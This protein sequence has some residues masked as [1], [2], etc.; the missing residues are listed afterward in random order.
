MLGKTPFHEDLLSALNRRNNTL[1]LRFQVKKT[2]IKLTGAV[3]ASGV[4][5]EGGGEH[6]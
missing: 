1:L 6:L 5:V 4:E 3:K 2:F